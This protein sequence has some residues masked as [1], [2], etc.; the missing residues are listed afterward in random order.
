MAGHSP[1]DGHEPI[2]PPVPWVL[3]ARSASALAEQ[4]SRLQRF[5]EQH[6]ELEPRDVAYSL[7]SDEAS[8][9]HRAVAVGVE[10]DE[11]LS[12]LSAISSRTPASNVVTG[13]VVAGGSTIFVFPGLGWHWTQMVVDLLDC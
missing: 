11:L 10:R 1:A 12:G 7:I 3:S 4:A 9:D 13:K 6:T 8:F 5:V 2:R